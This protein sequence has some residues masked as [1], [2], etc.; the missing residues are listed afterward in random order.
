M[1]LYFHEFFYF[2]LYVPFIFYFD[3]GTYDF[4]EIFIKKNQNKKLRTRKS[5]SFVKIILILL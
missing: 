1:H 4:S 2:A 3:S 5:A